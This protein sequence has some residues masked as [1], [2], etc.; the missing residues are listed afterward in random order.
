[1]LTHKSVTAAAPCAL[2]LP[3]VFSWEIHGAP[4]QLTGEILSSRCR[5]GVNECV[6]GA[7]IV[8]HRN[9]FCLA[10]AFFYFHALFSSHLF[11]H[12]YSVSVLKQQV[13]EINIPPPQWIEAMKVLVFLISSPLVIIYPSFIAGILF[14][15]LWHY[16]IKVFNSCCVTVLRTFWCKITKSPTWK[17][18]HEREKKIMIHTDGCDKRHHTFDESSL[19]WHL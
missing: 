16:G 13:A 5:E 11:V 7:D 2:L 14:S 3:P 18:V 12:L 9:M 4:W 8:C 15:V 19:I 1:M 6:R 17:R 10:N